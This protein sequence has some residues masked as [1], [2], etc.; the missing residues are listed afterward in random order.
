[1]TE[2]NNEKLSSVGANAAEKPDIQRV[3]A[4]NLAEAAEMHDRL[5][6]AIPSE[7]LG[8]NPVE[9]VQTTG[10][11]SGSASSIVHDHAAAISGTLQGLPSEK[12]MKRQVIN[13]I[14]KEIRILKKEAN[15]MRLP[16]VKFDPERYQSLVAKIRSLGQVLASL[17]HATY[18]SIKGL[19][20]KHVKNLG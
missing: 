16:F 3:E 15:R 14:E 19:W 5:E 8:E 1:M 7:N 17:A 12:V 4:V 10:N 2:G 6:M 18:E 13:S 11:N 20:L 9:D